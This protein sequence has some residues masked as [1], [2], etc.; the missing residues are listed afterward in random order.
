MGPSNGA[1]KVQGRR[2]INLCNQGEKRC[3]SSGLDT[4][5]SV[6]QVCQLCAGFCVTCLCRFV[7]EMQVL[8][9]VVPSQADPETDEVY[10]QIA[11]LPEADQT[12]ITNPDS[13][14]PEPQSC[15]VHSFCKTLRLTQAHMVDFL[16]FGGMRMIA[17]LHWICPSSH[18][19]RN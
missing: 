7:S 11:L 3:I 5:L 17:C 10:A 2:Q 12:K 1:D 6:V 8:K 16:F 18:P 13:P 14:L 15:N 9:K 4:G 19:G